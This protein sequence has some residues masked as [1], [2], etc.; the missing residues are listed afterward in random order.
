VTSLNESTKTIL[1]L[2]PPTTLEYEWRF[3]G[4][5][6]SILRHDLVADGEWTL[7]TLP[8]HRDRHGP[9]NSISF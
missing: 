7:L 2:D 4:E 1:A 9:G 3:K 8:H 5:T 6:E